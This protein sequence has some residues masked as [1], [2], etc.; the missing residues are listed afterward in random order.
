MHARRMSFRLGLFTLLIAL[1]ACQQRGALD[2]ASA[3]AWSKLIVAHTSGVVSRKS[4]VRVLFSG[5]VAAA[6][7][8]Q[9]ALK[10]DPAVPGEITL[11]GPRELVLVPSGELKPG[12]EYQVTLSADALS[13]VPSGIKAYQFSFHVQTPQF[14]IS[15]A[16][17]E[18]DPADDQR[19]I[20]RGTLVTAD[21]ED[22]AGVERILRATFRDSALPAVWSH[23]GDGREHRFTLPS[24]ERGE[25]AEVL[26]IALDGKAIG[27]AGSGLA[28]LA[29][30][31][32][33][34]SWWSMPTRSNPMAA[35]KSRW[36]SPTVWPRGRI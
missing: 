33:V 12:Q 18:S 29:C 1:A 30:P 2:P 23:S 35:R 3:D 8:L 24:V 17:L 25:Q 32:S 11:R 26:R 28:R 27:A 31:R 7:T 10:L 6:K 16:D 22:A 4:E 14:D 13:G 21:A 5:D 20:Q 15:L 9:A 36:R 34:N 19:M